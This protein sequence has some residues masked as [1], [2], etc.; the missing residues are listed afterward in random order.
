MQPLK[1]VF[2][3][4]LTDGFALGEDGKE[5]N[6]GAG[7]VPVHSKLF[8]WTEVAQKHVVGR[9][10]AAG[11]GRRRRRGRGGAAGHGCAAFLKGVEGA[12]GEE[13]EAEGVVVASVGVRRG[14]E[15]LQVEQ[16]VLLAH[17]GHAGNHVVPCVL[18][19]GV[20]MCWWG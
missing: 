16:L 20:R 14:K 4:V 5:L 18:W 9:I 8:N 11:G 2:Q 12:V 1:D 10:S 13:V 3:V 19:G 17:H 6:L 15:G 7:L